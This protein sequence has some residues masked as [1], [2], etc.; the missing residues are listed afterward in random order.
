MKCRLTTAPGTLHF[1]PPEVLVDDNPVY[2][3]A[4]DVFSF[5]GIALHVFSENGLATPSGQNMIDPISE[6]LVALSEA[7]KRKQ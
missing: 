1:I 3:T 6:K 5:G 2:G 4:M 7:E